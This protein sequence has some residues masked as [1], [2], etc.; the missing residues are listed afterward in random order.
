MNNGVHGGREGAKT[1]TA[2]A[3]V[4]SSP[5]SSRKRPYGDELESEADKMFR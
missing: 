2:V 1:T 4:G 3:A 5:A